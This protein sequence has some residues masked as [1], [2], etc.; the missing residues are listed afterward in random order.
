MKPLSQNINN[1]RKRLL[2]IGLYEHPTIQDYINAKHTR[3]KI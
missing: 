2:E 3:K 1:R